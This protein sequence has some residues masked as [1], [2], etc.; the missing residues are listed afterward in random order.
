MAPCAT[1]PTS[2]APTTT[3]SMTSTTLLARSTS[4]QAEG[5]SSTA[6]MGVGMLSVWCSSSS[7]WGRP[8]WK[9]QPFLYLRAAAVLPRAMWRLLLFW[10]VCACVRCCL[11]MHG[12]A[13][14]SCS[15]LQGGAHL[16][17]SLR[18][19]NLQRHPL[20]MGQAACRSCGGPVEGGLC[21]HGLASVGGLVKV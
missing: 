1:T 14:W 19:C 11:P 3:C 5:S 15:S 4:L 2:Q 6:N 17:G 13:I 8:P 9:A 20:E 18:S 7:S 16:T 21:H 12:A 10:K